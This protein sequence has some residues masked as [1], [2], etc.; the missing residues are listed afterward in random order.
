M[1]MVSFCEHFSLPVRASLRISFAQRGSPCPFFSAVGMAP[2]R[3]LMY[4]WV[5]GSLARTTGASRVAAA[6]LP[7]AL[8][9][10]LP[11]AASSSNDAGP[12]ALSTGPPPAG[13]GPARAFATPPSDSG[14]GPLADEVVR[15]SSEV[16]RH[17]LLYH[18]MRTP[19]LSDAAY[20]ALKQAMVDALARL[21]AAQDA[22]PAAAAAFARA[23]EAVTSVL[24]AVGA[25]PPSGSHLTKARPSPAF[26]FSAASI[27]VHDHCM[28]AI[29]TCCG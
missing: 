17:G 25:P 13:R 6:L 19:E 1:K 23:D 3:A 10:H 27:A 8:F 21:R 15:L 24:R 7:R 14:A 12:R 9:S 4:M 20:D 22:S 16:A 29:F 5:T 11:F 28:K 2:P 18:G 26:P